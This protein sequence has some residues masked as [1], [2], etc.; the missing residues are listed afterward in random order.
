[1]RYV[2]TVVLVM[3]SACSADP[4]ELCESARRAIR[5][6][7]DCL[8]TKDCNYSVERSMVVAGAH[9]HIQTCKAGG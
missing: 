2:V 7:E 1:M 4:E 8:V 6:H 5:K 3:L 9:Y